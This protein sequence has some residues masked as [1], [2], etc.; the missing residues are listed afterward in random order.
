VSPGNPSR[1]TAKPW[2]IK[3]DKRSPYPL[4]LR[5]MPHRTCSCWVKLRCAAD[6]RM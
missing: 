4:R 2:L 6:G 1:S 3:Q 5:I